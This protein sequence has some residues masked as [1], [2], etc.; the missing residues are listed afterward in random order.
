MA[1]FKAIDQS[2]LSG[3]TLFI[4]TKQIAS[5]ERETG[6]IKFAGGG[7]VKVLP[8]EVDWAAGLMLA[9]DPTPTAPV[10]KAA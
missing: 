7:S 3:N 8:A 6:L 2:G 1:L 4:N 10:P 9:E 5:M